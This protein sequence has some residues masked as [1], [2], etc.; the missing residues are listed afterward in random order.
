MA[1]RRNG[2]LYVGTTGNLTERIAAHKENRGA[3]FVRRYGVKTLVYFQQYDDYEIARTEEVR[4]KRWRRAWKLELIE[5]SNPQWLD[6]Y[7][8]MNS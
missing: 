2:T 7:E 5:E 3:A 4:I 8:T 1:S 6:L